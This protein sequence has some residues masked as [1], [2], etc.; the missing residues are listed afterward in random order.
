MLALA[1]MLALFNS[2]AAAQGQAVCF[3]EHA[4]FQGQR[5]CFADRPARA[6]DGLR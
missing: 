6:D 5:F 2:P 1:P 3:F 4:N